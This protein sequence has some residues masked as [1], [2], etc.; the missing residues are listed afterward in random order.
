MPP[1]ARV[2]EIP[3]GPGR[4]PAEQ[5]GPLGP[6]RPPGPPGPPGPQPD[7]IEWDDGS[8]EEEPPFIGPDDDADNF[9][10]EK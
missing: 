3:E 2:F 1:M 6:P 4:G 9:W 8:D 7:P 10:A 5:A